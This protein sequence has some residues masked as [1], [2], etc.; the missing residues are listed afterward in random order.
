MSSVTFLYPLKTSE[1]QRLS[2]VFREYKNVTLDINGL[3][4]KSFKLSTVVFTI[5]IIKFNDK[6]RLKLVDEMSFK[7]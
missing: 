3:T 4:T 2:D 7:M 1:N 5:T 6:I